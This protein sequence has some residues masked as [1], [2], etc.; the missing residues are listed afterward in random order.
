MLVEKGVIGTHFDPCIYIYLT[1][2]TIVVVY[3][4]DITAAGTRKKIDNIS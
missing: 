2:P 3:M 1:I 4:D